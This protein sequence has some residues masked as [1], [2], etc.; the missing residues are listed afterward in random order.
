MLQVMREDVELKRKLLVRSEQPSK[1][2]DALMKIA[3]SM[4][5]L[6]S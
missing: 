4:D 2:D 6:S 3:D 5:T 1:A